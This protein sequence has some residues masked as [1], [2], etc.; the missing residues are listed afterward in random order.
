[1]HPIVEEWRRCDRP[2][3]EVLKELPE[4][5]DPAITALIRLCEHMKMGLPFRN[6]LRAVEKVSPKKTDTGLYALLLSVW[7]HVSAANGRTLEADALLTR[8]NAIDEKFI[9]EELRASLVIIKGLILGLQ[10]NLLKREEL[11]RQGIAMFPTDSPRRRLFVADLAYF[12]ASLG[13][14]T[15]LD[16]DLENFAS[17]NPALFKEFVALIHFLRNLETGRIL[18][19]MECQTE[20]HAVTHDTLKLEFQD[21]ISDM[22]GV[23]NFM[24]DRWNVDERVPRKTGSPDQEGVATL[25]NWARVVDLLLA[26]R[27]EEALEHARKGNSEIVGGR[28]FKTFNLLRAELASGNGEAAHRLLE[29]RCQRGNN[30]F[31]DDF[32]MARAELL[33]GNAKSSAEHFRTARNAARRLNAERR[34]FFELR[35]AAE[36]SPDTV[37]R[38]TE[39]TTDAP[40]QEQIALPDLANKPAAPGGIDRLMGASK[41][42]ADVREQ[43]IRLSKSDLPVL[44]TGETGTGKELVAQAIHEMGARADKPFLAINC[45]S[46]SESL[47][48]S[49]L[50][51]HEKGAFTGAVRTHRGIFEE[52]GKG[53]VFLDEIGEI[54]PRL[55]IAFLR[56]LETG[57]IRP[58]GSARSRRFSARVIAATNA[59]LERGVEKGIFRKDL[60]FRLERLT[61]HIPPLRDRREDILPLVDHFLALGRRDGKR[62]V[63]SAELRDALQCHDW[64]GNVREVQN[65][66][67]RLR[68]MN[69]DKIAYDLSDLKTDWASQDNKNAAPDTPAPTPTASEDRWPMTPEAIETLLRKGRSPLRRMEMLEEIFVRYKRLSRGEVVKIL[70]ISPQTATQYLKTLCAK[71]VIEKVT[72]SGSPRAQ[73][74]TIRGTPGAWTGRLTNPPG[75]VQ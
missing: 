4:P 74:F 68:I 26:R 9:P 51:G 8:A 3:L 33:S 18:E 21:T 44:V 55:Q 58:V 40:P 69:S 27:P 72:P 39:S 59:D 48:E 7:A 25:P 37:L 42:M 64:P 54:T 5:R 13:R 46:V 2:I 63:L 36:L 34:F 62:A 31:L 23:L 35:M 16:P 15:E 45:G 57:E 50:F 65:L 43:I 11:H 73:Y 49:E 53:T 60:Y 29:L 19:A 12:L 24:R 17:E 38:L 32:F 10:G 67:E 6:A 1:M 61:V 28:T 47:L 56:S 66:V 20:F 30:H 75:V 14:G 71:G 41:A 22:T 52:A 70:G